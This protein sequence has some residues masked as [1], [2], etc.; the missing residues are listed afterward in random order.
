M[1]AI[2]YPDLFTLA[3]ISGRSVAV[4][5]LALVPLATAYWLLARA[6]RGRRV[7]LPASSNAPASLRS[8]LLANYDRLRRA[9]EAVPLA[10]DA[11]ARL[12]G[13]TRHM[14]S[15]SAR[16][17]A[18]TY[19]AIEVANRLLQAS[20]AYDARGHLSIRHRRLALWPTVEA[21][22]RTGLN[23]LG[24]QVTQAAQTQ[25]RPVVEDQS[26]PAA[27]H[28][29]APDAPRPHRVQRRPFTLTDAP[30][31]SLFC[32]PDTATNSSA[33]PRPES[34]SRLPRRLKK[35]RAS[36]RSHGQMPLWESVA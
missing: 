32:H 18:R 34:G 9:G 16:S 36:R 19:R 13:R 29:A 31:L 25:T 22:V 5:M 35:K 10:T 33:P 7:L 17:L 8:E 20:A 26:A 28:D 14:S 15:A 1:S 12:H 24:T 2:H 11:W 4:A 23:A 6:A 21:A 30:R 27:A 3:A